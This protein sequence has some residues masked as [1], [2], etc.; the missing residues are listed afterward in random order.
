MPRLISYNPKEPDV[1]KT[2]L[3]SAVK[4]LWPE[5]EWIENV[6]LREK[7]LR[8]WCVA[9]E[10]SPLTP[11]D[12]HEIPYTLLIPNCKVSFI[13]HK[14]SVVHISIESARAMLKFYGD[15]LPIDMDVLA[16]GAILIDVGKLLE[17]ERIGGKLRQSAK[18]QLLRHPF[19]G[20]GLCQEMGLPDE[21]THMVATH[22]KE[23]SLGKRTAEGWIV[24]HADFMSFE[25]MKDRLVVI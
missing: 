6:G 2:N 13:A 15:Q 19:S 25:A 5:L 3:E 7:T 23:G 20:A 12:L 10:R 8:T 1:S 24:H 22:A 16:S 17:Y 11:P 9:F 14:R 18:G 4:E 21:V